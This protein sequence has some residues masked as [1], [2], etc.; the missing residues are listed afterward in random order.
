LRSL[1]SDKRNSSVQESRSL[2]E[3]IS[4]CETTHNVRNADRPAD[5][6]LNNSRV[7]AAGVLHVARAIERLAQQ[8][9]KR[10]GPKWK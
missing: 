7:E 2:S 9:K 1:T 5:Q 6:F 4:N 8:Q 3:Q 10:P